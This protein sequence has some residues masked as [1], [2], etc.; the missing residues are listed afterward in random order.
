VRTPV[1]QR[2]CGD[3]GAMPGLWPA[4]LQWCEARSMTRRFQIVVDGQTFEVTEQVRKGSPVL[5]FTWTSGPNDGY[6]FSAG[7]SNGEHITQDQATDLVRAF[8]RDVDPG[9]GYLTD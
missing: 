8:L 9:T 3:D 5:D 6:G 2:A 7:T 4:T 1:A